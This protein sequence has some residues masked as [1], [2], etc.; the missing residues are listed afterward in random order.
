MH[1]IEKEPGQKRKD[2]VN[3]LKSNK[4]PLPHVGWNNIDLKLKK[5]QTYNCVFLF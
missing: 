5:T 2:F 4:L 3:K 1:F